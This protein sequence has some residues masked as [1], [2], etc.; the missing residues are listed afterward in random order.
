[1]AAQGDRYPAGA[2]ADCGWF[3]RQL[4]G[5]LFFNQMKRIGQLDLVIQL[6][7]VTLML[8]IGSLMISD[9]SAPCGRR[10]TARA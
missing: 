9:S 10:A 7:Y 1:M 5:V 3:R 8:T 6:S 2:G 4:Q